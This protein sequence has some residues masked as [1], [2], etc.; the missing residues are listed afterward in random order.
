MEF[1]QESAERIAKLLV[2]ERTTS[3]PPRVKRKGEDDFFA[4]RKA[5]VDISTFSGKTRFLLK[6]SSAVSFR[7]IFG[8]AKRMP[9]GATFLS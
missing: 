9:A 5:A 2:G 3:R 7:E 1:A 4:T 8:R 6:S